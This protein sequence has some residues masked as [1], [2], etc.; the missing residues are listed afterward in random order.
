MLGVPLEEGLARTW[1]G[2]CRSEGQSLIGPRLPLIFALDGLVRVPSG[3]AYGHEGGTLVH[4]SIDG[5]GRV[6]GHA[7]E[8]AALA[9]GGLVALG[10]LSE[11]ELKAR[12]R[13]QAD[14]GGSDWSVSGFGGGDS[15]SC[16]AGGSS[17]DSGGGS[18]CGSSCGGGD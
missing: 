5:F 8:H 7:V 4:R 12:R 2:A 9:G 13:K 17:G 10:L 16:D 6:G 1:A 3:W 18:S 14:G 11:A 15:S